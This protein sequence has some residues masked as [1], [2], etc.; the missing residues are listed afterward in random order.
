MEIM[1]PCSNECRTQYEFEPL[2]FKYTRGK[3]NMD[4]KKRNYSSTYRRTDT[5]HGK[6]LCHKG[7]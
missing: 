3:M 5:S 2:F 6:M 4:T 1:P 7:S